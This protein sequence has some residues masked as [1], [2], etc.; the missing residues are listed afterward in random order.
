MISVWRIGYCASPEPTEQAILSSLG[1]GSTF[2]NGRW[3]TRSPA[4]LVYAGASR[5]LCQLEKRV[6]CNGANPAHQ[7]LMRL[8]LPK[9]ATL[10]N[11][12]DLGLPAHW[13]SS[14]TITQSLGLAWLASGA[15]LGLWVP[16]YI[17]P[18]DKNLLIN[19]AHPLYSAIRLTIERNPFT[20][21]PRLFAV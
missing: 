15:S 7:A 20:F 13:R 21:D 11:V 5:A 14:E 19:P 4:Q 18:E 12:K 10:L 16:S 1:F 2:G 3:H 17:E 6:H 8:D 9:A